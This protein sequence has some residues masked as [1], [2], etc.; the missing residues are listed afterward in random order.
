MSIA[1]LNKLISFQN[2]EEVKIAFRLEV[3]N[4][5]QVIKNVDKKFIF[6]ERNIPGCKE[7]AKTER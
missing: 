6:I 2:L 5:I 1:V 7:F 3:V 4:N